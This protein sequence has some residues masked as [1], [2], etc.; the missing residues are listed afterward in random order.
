MPEME[1]S[2]KRFQLRLDADGYLTDYNDWDEAVAQELAKREGLGELTKDM[3]DI[4]KFMRGYYREYKFFP[5]VRAVCKNVHQPKN[6]VTEKFI[7][8]VKAW[9]IAGLPNPGEEVNIFRDW[10]PL[11][12]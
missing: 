12:Y 6:C 7:D 3:F 5:I 9:K 8:P 10:N 11:G 1:S 4:L 2:G